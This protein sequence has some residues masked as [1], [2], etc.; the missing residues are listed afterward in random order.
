MR[1]VLVLCEV[2]RLG[3]REGRCGGFLVG[4]LFIVRVRE[5]LDA[6]GPAE[7]PL[8]QN[9]GGGLTIMPRVEYRTM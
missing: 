6:I 1:R 2:G 5:E 8:A 4:G 7:L 9:H 3:E